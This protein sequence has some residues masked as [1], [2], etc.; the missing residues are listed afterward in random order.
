MS[1]APLRCSCGLK[2]ERRT[3]VTCTLSIRRLFNRLLQA[4]LEVLANHTAFVIIRACTRAAAKHAAALGIFLAVT[5]VRES[6][7]GADSCG[8][9]SATVRPLGWTIT[10]ALDETCVKSKE[11][12]KTKT[13][14]ETVKKESVSKNDPI[15][16]LT[17]DDWEH[18]YEPVC[19][20]LCVCVCVRARACVC[21]HD[22]CSLHFLLVLPHGVYF[23]SIK[24]M[25][26]DIDPYA[27]L[28]I[29]SLPRLP[30]TKAE[31][32]YL[33]MDALEKELPGT[34]KISHSVGLF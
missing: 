21:M 11:I 22:L 7:A 26:C 25:V 15:M 24:C 8:D 32:T 23:R 10:H 33:F 2:F 17:G 5:C 20:V 13:M 31:D 1:T 18:V 34:R 3:V 14:A 19:F 6:A 29:P 4:A 12:Y 30:P 28:H 16:P 27:L 9:F